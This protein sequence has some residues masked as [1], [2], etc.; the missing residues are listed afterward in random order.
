MLFRG[1]PMVSSFHHPLD[2]PIQS[3]RSTSSALMKR[4]Q[5]LNDMLSLHFFLFEMDS[6]SMKLKGSWTAEFIE[7]DWTIWCTGRAMELQMTSGY[8][9]KMF[10][11]QDVLLRN[12]I[13]RTLKLH[14]IFWLQYMPPSPFEP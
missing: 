11:E 10:Q 12:F 1:M 6:L 7:G 5:S 13:S 9:Q 3:S 8:L 2:V 14:S 4:I